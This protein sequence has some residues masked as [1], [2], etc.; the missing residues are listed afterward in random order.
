MSINLPNRQRFVIISWLIFFLFLVKI[1]NER[2]NVYSTD[3]C[4][5]MIA[6]KPFEDRNLFAVRQRD[7]LKQKQNYS[8]FKWNFKT[9]CLIGNYTYMIAI[10]HCLGMNYYVNSLGAIGCNGFH[11]KW[12]FGTHGNWKNQNPGGRF[13]ATS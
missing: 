12:M 3:R 11:I 1:N 6:I 8:S 7:C 5:V 2:K 13:G 4:Q 10:S 9:L